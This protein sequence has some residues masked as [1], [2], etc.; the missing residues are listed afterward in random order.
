MRE[1]VVD[2]QGSTDF[3][4]RSSVANQMTVGVTNCINI[5]TRMV[6]TS[7]PEHEQKWSVFVTTLSSEL[8]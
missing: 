3:W 7:P 2:S 4:E 5:Q 1:L 8:V 6:D